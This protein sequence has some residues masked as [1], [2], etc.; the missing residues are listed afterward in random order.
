[1]RRMGLIL[2]LSIS[3]LY[4]I[5]LINETFTNPGF[6]TGWQVIPSVTNWEKVET[7]IAG[8]AAPGELK[9]NY[10]PAQ[11]GTFRMV[12]Q[13]FDTRKAHNMTLCFQHRYF[14]FSAIGADTIGV[15]WSNDLVNWQTIWAV[16]PTA[17]IG[18][19]LVSGINISYTMGMSANSYIA[20]FYK[21]NTN[22]TDGWFIDDVVLSHS[23]F[24]GSGTWEGNS[25]YYISGHLIVPN[26]HTF[27][28]PE[29]TMIRFSSGYFLLVDGRLLINGTAT[30]PVTLTSLNPSQYWR[31]V[32][33]Q[34]I[35][36]ANDS[37]LINHTIIEFSNEVG[38]YAFDTNKI[39]ISNSI[40]RYNQ[41]ASEN[42]GLFAHYSNII[43]ENCQFY[44][45]RASSYASG[46]EFFYCTAP[47][48]RYNKFFDNVSTDSSFG[49]L[50]LN[51]SNIDGVYG[52]LIVNND[53]TNSIDYGGVFIYNCTGTFKLNLIANNTYAGIV[54]SYGNVL[55]EN[56]TVVNNVIAGVLLNNSGY[57][58][59]INTII[60]G[61]QYSIYNVSPSSH[62]TVAYSC[63][64][65]GIGEYGIG[66]NGI[67][68][69]LY[70]N[71]ISSNP[72]FINPTVAS[73]TSYNAL[74]ADFRLQDY[75]PCIDAGDPSSPLNLDDTIED[76]GKYS[77]YLRPVITKS[78]DVP[79]DQGRQLDMVWNRN[80][81][82]ETYYFQAFYSVWRDGTDRADN[83]TFISD[84]S[85]IT[86]GMQ[87]GE[88]Q[89]CWRDGDR[90]WYYLLQ[91]PAAQ[92]PTYGVI[93]PTLRDS[94]ATGTHA[95]D[96]KVKYHYSNGCFESAPVSGYS[97]DNIP[98]YAPARVEISHLSGNNFNLTWDE[99]TEGGWEGNSYPEINQITYKI[100][101]GDTPDFEISPAS[102]I[103]STTDPYSVL[104]NQN[105][106][107]RFYRIIASDSE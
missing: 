73:G 9:F 28:I 10:Y 32:K 83:V 16:A 100:Y 55:I 104:I 86:Y 27:T 38:L 67:L 33:L 95:A 14:N 92:E 41:G 35:N 105:D 70:T 84:P 36:P 45:N 75:S 37:T 93:V 80:D 66:G 29:N 5:D 43:V 50:L 6:P 64:M 88:N 97:V 51:H 4:G 87:T 98:P 15:Q 7:N 74:L 69:S 19:A 1:M 21:G 102:Y 44:Y 101:S 26:G 46:A 39:R 63:I 94:S 91:V 18:P 59:V 24:L 61:N 76:I 49:A 42:A 13:S 99:V 62:L 81:I 52:N 30:H 71:N 20:F 53:R 90:T 96:Y 54:I 12:S 47:I 77:R 17:H 23:N 89:I 65:Y 3:F 22:N 31:G 68:P 106:V 79:Y 58:D 57:L 82:D 103:L 25:T 8:G 60:W 78:A 40:F 48:V 72:L 2:L 85:Q 56:C 11:T 107:K 34:S